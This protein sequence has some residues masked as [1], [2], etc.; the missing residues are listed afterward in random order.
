MVGDALEDAMDEEEDE[1]ES[2]QVLTH[3]CALSH[4]QQLRRKTKGECLTISAI[5]LKPA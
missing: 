2:E 4:T 1:E 5:Y 3:A